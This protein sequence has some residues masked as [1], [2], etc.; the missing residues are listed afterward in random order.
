[1]GG[2]I[3]IQC[4]YYTNNIIDYI[5]DIAMECLYIVVMVIKNKLLIAMARDA[6]YYAK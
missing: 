2:L 1:M 3:V 6:F 4:S 5:S